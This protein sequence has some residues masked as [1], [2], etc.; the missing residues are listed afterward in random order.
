M[1]EKKKKVYLI[2]L[3]PICYKFRKIISLVSNHSY[4]S[5]HGRISFR[6]VNSLFQDG[7]SGHCQ[8][9]LQFFTSTGPLKL[10]KVLLISIAVFAVAAATATAATSAPSPAP[11]PP[12]APA[13]AVRSTLAPRP[14]PCS[15]PSPAPTS[16]PTPAARSA[17]STA[18]CPTAAHSTTTTAAARTTSAVNSVWT[19][20]P[21]PVS[22]TAV[23]VPS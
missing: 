12:P 21:A 3:Q 13:P 22:A 23:A 5:N 8:H 11:A 15:T 6:G 16:T 9:I 18:E 10:S 7:F 19:V 2:N 17:T 14:A 20:A 4:L 1:N